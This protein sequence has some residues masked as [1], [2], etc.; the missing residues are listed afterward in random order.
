MALLTAHAE[1]DRVEGLAECLP[2]L[3]TFAAG[4]L[5]P[6]AATNLDG[7]L[8]ELAADPRLV[9]VERLPGRA[10]RFGELDRPLPVGVRERLGVDQ[11][12]SH[13]AEAINALR[14]GTSVAIA[15]GTASGKSLCYQAPIAEAVAEGLR[16][17]TALLVFP[18]KA[19]A[20]DQLHALARMEIPRLVPASYD[21]DCGTEERTWTRTHANVVFSNPEMLHHGILPHHARWATFL[22]RLRYVVIDELHILRGVFGTHVAHLLRRLRRLCSHYGSSPVFVFTSATIGQP[23]ILASELC[24]L[25]VVEITK[26]GSPRGERL[27][28]LLWNPSA[29]EGDATPEW[30]PDCAAEWDSVRSPRRLTKALILGRPPSDSRDIQTNVN[31]SRN[32]GD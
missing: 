18:T 2:A 6:L 24:G 32:R 4:P 5:G 3:G 31:K 20:H 8:A 25:P 16:A 26:D 10:A 29:K 1:G 11:F 27:F 28:A 23:S 21:G 12:W 13:Q 14:A 9:H 19:L 15:T 22:M 7:F 30:C 17:A